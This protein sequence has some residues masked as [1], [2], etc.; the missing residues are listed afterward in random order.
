MALSAKTILITGASQRI[1]RTLAL[2]C[3]TAGADIFLHYASSRAAADSTRAEIQALGRQAHLL[4]ADLGDPLQAASLIDRAWQIAPVDALINNAA[5]FEQLDWQDT[6][7]EAWQRHL[8]INLTAP[9]QL[10]QAF[11][12]RLD[13]DASGCIVNLLDWRALR[14]GA[15]HLPYTISKAGLAALT[16]SLAQAFAPRIRVNALALGAILPPSDGADTQGLLEN[17]PARR[18][19]HL[20]EVS[21]AVL[22]L[23]DGAEYITGEIIHLDGGRHLV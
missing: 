14:P 18:W 6:S 4:P 9:F 23:L 11:A 13:A 16:R 12:R 20:E 15:D 3:A 22:F 10:S 19:A 2:A 1:G 17:I 7:L 8:Q 5:I 21:Q